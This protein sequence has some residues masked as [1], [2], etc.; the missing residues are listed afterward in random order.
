MANKKSQQDVYNE[1]TRANKEKANEAMFTTI[2]TYDGADR[3]KFEE[4]IDDIKHVK[5]VDVISVQK[6]SS[7]QKERYIR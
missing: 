3:S 1:L 5:S 7:D 6:S 4:W 2:K